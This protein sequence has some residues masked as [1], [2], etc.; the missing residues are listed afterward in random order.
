[1]KTLQILMSTYNGAKYIR[2]Q[3]DSLLEQDCEAKGTASF[4]IIVRDDGSSD[5]TQDILEEYAGRYPEK[6]SWYQGEN[7]GVIRSFFEL[8]QKSGASD[9][10]AF[11][12]QDDY[13]MPD[14]MS[15]AVETLQTMKRMVPCYIAAGR[16]WWIRTCSL[17][18]PRSKGPLCVRIFAMQ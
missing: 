10:Y 14:K 3:M 4:C 9:Y 15:H 1:M 12:D 8:L 5:G 16:V 2:E 7:H 18:S 6:I 11:C 13:W 17:W